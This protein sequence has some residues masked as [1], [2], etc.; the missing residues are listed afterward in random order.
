MLHGHVEGGVLH[1]P[2]DIA[3]YRSWWVKVT[4]ER[5][6]QRALAWSSQLDGSFDIST[7]VLINCRVRG[8]VRGRRV[9]VAKRGGSPIYTYVSVTAGRA[10]LGVDFVMNCTP[11]GP[12]WRLYSIRTH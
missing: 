9:I 1:L 10:Y 11:K 2:A 6:A 8:R 5:L 3:R 4:G 7:C 12:A